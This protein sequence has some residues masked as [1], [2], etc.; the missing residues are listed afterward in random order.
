MNFNLLKGFKLSARYFFEFDC[1]SL[2]L[3]GDSISY[4]TVDVDGHFCEVVRAPVCQCGETE[5]EI[6]TM[7]FGEISDF[8]GMVG[9][10]V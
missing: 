6:A 5:I 8:L 10:F 7:I 4:D 1:S 3:G 9:N 2:G